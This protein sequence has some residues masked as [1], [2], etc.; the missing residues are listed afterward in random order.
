VDVGGGVG[1]GTG[2]TVITAAEL[3]RVLASTFTLSAP[4]GTITLYAV[5]T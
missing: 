1:S 2:Q 5:V 4:N 3:E